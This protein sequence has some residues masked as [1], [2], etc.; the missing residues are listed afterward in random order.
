MEINRIR[1]TSVCTERI[2]TMSYIIIKILRFM[3]TRVAFHTLYFAKF[4]IALFWKLIDCSYI[5][6]LPLYSLLEHVNAKSRTI[7]SP[8]TGY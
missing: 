4:L 2:E 1:N 3:Q 6:D 7:R 5:F 8:R